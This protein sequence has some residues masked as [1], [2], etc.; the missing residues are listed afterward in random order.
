M[1]NEETPECIKVEWDD[2][3][4][5]FHDDNDNAKQRIRKVN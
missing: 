5:K 2:F 3:L 1:S 4:Q